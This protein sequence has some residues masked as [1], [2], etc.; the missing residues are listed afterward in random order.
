HVAAA[1]G[2]RR[3][4]TWLRVDTATNATHAPTTAARNG[5]LVTANAIVTGPSTY[6]WCSAT[7]ATDTGARSTRSGAS[8]S[9][10]S[11]GE[12]RAGASAGIGL[13]AAGRSDCVLFR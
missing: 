7:V 2:E 5:R 8:G 6:S 4:S 1:S 11:S 12:L 3:A 10:A 13:R 9:N